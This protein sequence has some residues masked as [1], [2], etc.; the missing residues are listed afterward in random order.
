MIHIVKGFSV[1]S[2][3]N[4]KCIM[5]RKRNWFEKITYC[6]ILRIGYYQLGKTMDTVEKSVF[7]W[8][9]RILSY[10]NYVI[11]ICNGGYMPLYIC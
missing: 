4:L 6:I 10:W 1:V 9:E 8:R 2:E 5:L 7:V 3:S 11:W